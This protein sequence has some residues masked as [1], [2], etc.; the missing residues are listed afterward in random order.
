[1]IDLMS[2]S[3]ET[4]AGYLVAI[5]MAIVAYWKTKNLR[6][7]VDAF[8]ACDPKNP[9]SIVAPETEYLPDSIWKMDLRTLGVILDGL[10]E[11]EAGEVEAQIGMLE[12]DRVTAYKIIT[13]KGVYEIENGYIARVIDLSA[14]SL[15]ERDAIGR[16]VGDFEVDH[17]EQQMQKPTNVLSRKYNEVFIVGSF[18]TIGV[19][20]IGL[21]VGDEP[22]KKVSLSAE[23]LGPMGS[24]RYLKFK[25]W[26]YSDT[27]SGDTLKLTVMHGH[28][29]S[30]NGEEGTVWTKSK[31]Y[32]FDLVD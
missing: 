30:S 19:K 32:V 7:A 27:I 26:N 9:T 31:D 5:I 16:R 21:I 29:G 17:F 11:E 20:T 25:L 14:P 23:N 4:L 24:V 3:P 18:R 22:I 8:I 2:V 13:S 1:M 12:K 15:V 10:P 28:L 6:D